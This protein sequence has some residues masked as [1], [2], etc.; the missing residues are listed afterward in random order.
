MSD[1]F[2]APMRGDRCTYCGAQATT[3]FHGVQ[4]T[5]VCPSCLLVRAIHSSVDCAMA[6][7]RSGRYT[8]EQIQRALTH[9]TTEHAPGRKGIVRVLE[10]RLRNA[11]RPA[12]RT[13]RVCGCT[14]SDCRQCI[15]RTGQP[16]HWVEPDLCSAC[17]HAPATPVQTPEVS[18]P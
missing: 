13:C 1:P 11:R 17:A 4:V 3:G 14:D 6:D 5:L 18:H 15:A 16:C 9:E 2:S 12:A 7:L 10:S 8:S